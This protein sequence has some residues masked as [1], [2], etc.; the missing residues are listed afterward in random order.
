MSGLTT[1]DEIEIEVELRINSMEKAMSE[2][3]S[4]G[5]FG[6]GDKRLAMVINA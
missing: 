3:D 6:S 1:D 4:Q 5:V 2:L